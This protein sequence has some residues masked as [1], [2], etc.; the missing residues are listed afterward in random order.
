M[1][2]E[3]EALLRD[4]TFEFVKG[5]GPG[6]Q[7]RN[8]RMTAVRLT[9][10]P[11]GIVIFSCEQRT[12]GDNR[13]VAIDRLKEKLEARNRVQA[14]RIP[15][16]TPRSAKRKRLESKAARSQVKRQRQG[17]SRNDFE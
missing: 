12:Q 1:A 14:P 7:N 16:R 8:R 11:S 6:G 5:S 10:A 4:C 3:D 13:R 9:H 15:T 2:D 17:P